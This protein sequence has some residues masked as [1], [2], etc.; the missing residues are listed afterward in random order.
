MFRDII[1]KRK[2]SLLSLFFGIEK[3]FY[4]FEPEEVTYLLMTIT[5]F[6]DAYRCFVHADSTVRSAAN[7][8]ALS[9]SSSANCLTGNDKVTH[10]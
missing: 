6:H 2:N 8:G 3:Q 10:S 4:F 9:R 5:L 7:N 1:R